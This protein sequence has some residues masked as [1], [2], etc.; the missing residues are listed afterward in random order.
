MSILKVG[1]YA[2]SR[3]GAN[4]NYLTF[5]SDNP[6]S[7]SFTAKHWDGVLEYSPDAQNWYEWDAS[8]INSVD[9]KIYLRGLGNS[10]ITGVNNP[11]YRMTI[12][13][14][15]SSGVSCTGN[16]MTLLDHVSPE[17]AVMGAMCFAQMFRATNLT[18]APEL[19][20]TTLAVDCYRAMFYG[21]TNLTVAPELPATTLVESCYRGMFKASGISIA[22]ELPAT[23]LAS[24]CYIFMFQDCT[25][26][27]TA[28]DLPATVLANS[29]YNSM[30]YGCTNLTAAPE[31][32]AT[33]LAN[34]CYQNMF[35]G[36]S[37]KISTTQEGIYQTPWRIPSVGAIESVATGWNTDMLSG[38][39]GTFTG[40]PAI[41]TTYYQAT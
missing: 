26:L 15:S 3:I 32:P 30:L 28:P 2:S 40:N 6:F 38:T 1:M 12:T 22:P 10:V 8:E 39:G 31:L 11:A 37:I 34:Y 5:S 7:I 20:A 24:Y 9:N 41:N 36:T 4:Q 19:P 16:I 21:C 23:T 27:T 29:C 35:Y 25:S 18:T 14:P 17:T 33:V 13:S